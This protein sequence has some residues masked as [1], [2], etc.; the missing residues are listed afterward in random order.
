M[1]QVYGIKQNQNQKQDQNQ[2][3]NQNQCQVQDQDQDQAQVQVQYQNQR[4]SQKQQTR[5]EQRQDQFN[6]PSRTAFKM[7]LLCSSPTRNINISTKKVLLRSHEKNNTPSEDG[8]VLVAKIKGT[9]PDIFNL[10]DGG[11][12]TDHTISA[13]TISTVSTPTFTLKKLRLV[14]KTNVEPNP[15][16]YPKPHL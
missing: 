5:Q 15:K 3:Q 2:N 9:E 10:V 8:T 16:P 4:Q 14:E 13:K 1:N 6:S 12:G 11:A 7:S